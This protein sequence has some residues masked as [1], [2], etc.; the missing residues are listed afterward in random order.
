MEYTVFT[1]FGGSDDG[2]GGGD[3]KEVNESVQT[4]ERWYWGKK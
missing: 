2:G 1:M 3:T 4:V